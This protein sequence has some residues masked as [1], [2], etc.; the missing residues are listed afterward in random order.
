MALA[1]TKTDRPMLVYRHVREAILRSVFD[2]IV[3]TDMRASWES[4]WKDWFVYQDTVEDERK[5]GKVFNDSLLQYN[6]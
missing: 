6:Q 5:P 1:L 2:P 3:K 4:T